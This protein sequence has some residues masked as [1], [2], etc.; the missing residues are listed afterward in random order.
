MPVY[1]QQRERGGVMMGSM[2]EHARLAALIRAEQERISISTFQ[3]WL[4]EI[5]R[6]L[7]A[8]HGP[9]KTLELLREQVRLAEDEERQKNEL[10]E[11]L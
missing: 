11:T 8:E 6:S 7:R 2:I 3:G 1:R 10:L 9:A 5:R 4:D